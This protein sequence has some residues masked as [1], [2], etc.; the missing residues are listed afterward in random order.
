MEEE[1]HVI[2]VKSPLYQEPVYLLTNSGV[3][4]YEAAYGIYLKYLKRW[5][6]EQIYRVMKEK[7]NIED[8]RVMKYRRLRNV[9]SLMMAA[10]YLVARLVYKI[11]N[12]TK[13]THERIIGVAK[14]IREDGKFLYY[15]IIDGIKVLVAQAACKP[16]FFETV[17]YQPPAYSLFYRKAKKKSG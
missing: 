10:L 8:I 17:F 1:M 15:A 16:V 13:L 6:I 7:F 5:G 3:E 9:F 2:I 12:N 11:G 14:R 4:T